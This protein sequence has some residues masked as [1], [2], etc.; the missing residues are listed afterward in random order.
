[1]YFFLSL[2][3]CKF[4]FV[5][6]LGKLENVHR[7]NHFKIRFVV[8][9]IG[10]E[11]KHTTAYG[12]KAQH[13]SNQWESKERNTTDSIGRCKCGILICP[14]LLC[15][16]HRCSVHGFIVSISMIV[17][18]LAGHDWFKWLNV[19]RMLSKPLSTSAVAAVVIVTMCVCVCVCLGYIVKYVCFA[20]KSLLKP[21]K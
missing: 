17:F 16:V 13:I 5:R 15:F 20:D 7:S 11:P 1:M 18:F 6:I 4:A 2:P 3:L 14:N 19:Q 9:Y 12:I 10:T 8:Q 21:S